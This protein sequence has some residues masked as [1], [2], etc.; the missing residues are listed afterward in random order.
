MHDPAK[1]GLDGSEFTITPA[2]T[3]LVTGANGFVG[4]RVVRTLLSY[5]FERVRCLM[6]TANISEFREKGL[7]WENVEIVEGNLLSRDTCK[8]VTDGASVIYH[9]AAGV[10]KSY[11]GCV[12][13]SAVATRN[14]LDAAASEP[15]MKRFVSISSIAVYSNEKIPRGGLF[16]EACE[17]DARLVDRNEP[18]TY[19]KAKQD[20][21]VLD[22]GK[23]AN[24]PY[25]I[26]RPSVVFG[27]GKSKI[28]DR[29]GTATF[30]VFLHL[31]GSNRIPL[32]YV[33]N[34]AEA[35][36]LAG[37]RRG[38]DGQVFNVFDDDL[39][40]SREFLK[41]YK[42]N[43]RRFLSVPVPYTVWYCFCFLWEWYSRW[44]EGQLPPVLNRR[45]CSVYWKG[46]TYSNEKAKELLGWNPRVSMDEA[47]KKYFAY[48]RETADHR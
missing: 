26:V 44:S 14:L 1:V 2:D 27:P 29:I 22:Y 45:V 18:Y 13:N 47:L 7:K 4:S 33:D 19:G 20:E 10:E 32:T 12:L 25:V 39:P 16:D 40:K 11:A 31:G 43:V 24:L 28:T 8:A 36:V 21:I 37:L 9:L 35:I 3:I 48:V 34:C 15:K 5:G 42:R 23:R 38:I 30:G 41:L 46:N 6:R 17:V